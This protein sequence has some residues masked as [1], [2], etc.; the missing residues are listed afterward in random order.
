MGFFFLGS[1][2]PYVFRS[3][4][5]VSLVHTCCGLFSH[6]RSKKQDQLAKPSREASCWTE[7]GQTAPEAKRKKN[8]AKRK[9]YIP[10]VM[11][12]LFSHNSKA[13]KQAH[14]LPSLCLAFYSLASLSYERQSCLLAVLL[15]VF[16]STLP[17]ISCFCS[18]SYVIAVK[19]AYG[20]LLQ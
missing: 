18:V 8:S 6:A 2:R 1:V 14:I 20:W 15:L 17:S 11:G 5:I 4:D 10:Y 13:K 16:R 9:G 19:T 7:P 3:P 12:K